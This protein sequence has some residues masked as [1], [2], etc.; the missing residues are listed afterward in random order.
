[1]K[2]EF[3]HRVQDRQ[4]EL[5]RLL[6]RSLPR[7]C[8]PGDGRPRCVV[9]LAGGEVLGVLR[10]GGPEQDKVGHFHIGVE[11]HVFIL[12]GF[13]LSAILHAKKNLVSHAKQAQQ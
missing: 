12:K 5:L 1:M 4:L 7:P 2:F 3:I 8:S 13:L 6:P 11:M 10:W 9:G